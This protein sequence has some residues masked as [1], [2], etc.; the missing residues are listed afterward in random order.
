MNK[1]TLFFSFLMMG[2][3]SY[4]SSIELK[5]MIAEDWKKEALEFSRHGQTK[6]KF[7]VLYIDESGLE[8]SQNI[9][10]YQNGCAGQ[11][12]CRDVILG[13]SDSEAEKACVKIG[14]TLPDE[15][16][17]NRLM[18]E[19]DHKISDNKWKTKRLTR[20]GHREMR[21]V[22]PDMFR[23]FSPQARIR[24]WFWT[25]TT[26]PDDGRFKDL[27]TAFEMQG[28]VF[29]T[30]GSIGVSERIEYL[31]VRCVR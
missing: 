24:G 4:A 26:V 17:Y 31:G 23:Y 3:Q 2:T 9:G 25:R 14:G 29:V 11:T 5:D 18:T 21:K 27:A 13:T 30:G 28:T 6:G 20:K 16:D 7:E 8:W 1:V 10:L 15:A 19:F 12:K 22:F